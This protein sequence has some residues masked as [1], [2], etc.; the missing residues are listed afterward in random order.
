MMSYK[1]LHFKKH[2]SIATEREKFLAINTTFEAIEV[3]TKSKL[4][5]RTI[6]HRCCKQGW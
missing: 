6:S 5:Q 1:Q 3:V 4:L 2:P